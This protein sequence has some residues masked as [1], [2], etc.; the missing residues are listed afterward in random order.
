MTTGERSFA[1]LKTLLEKNQ[2]DALTFLVECDREEF[3]AIGQEMSK[4][5]MDGDKGMLSLL[6]RAAA[7]RKHVEMMEG[8]MLYDTY[9][10]YATPKER[11]EYRRTLNPEHRALLDKT[12]WQHKDGKEALV[13]LLKKAAVPNTKR[14]TCAV[15]AGGLGATGTAVAGGSAATAIGSGVCLAILTDVIITGFEEDEATARLGKGLRS[16]LIDKPKGWLARLRKS[17]EAMETPEG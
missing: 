8:G 3:I 10:S 2:E 17:N 13:H 12:M 5:V 11:E 16:V 6:E 4:H 15:V 9:L 7:R 1:M 14:A